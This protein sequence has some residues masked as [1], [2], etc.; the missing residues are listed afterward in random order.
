MGSFGATEGSRISVSVTA[1]SL[2][3]SSGFVNDRDPEKNLLLQE[4]V[5]A[6]LQTN[7]L[8]EVSLPIG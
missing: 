6:L 3:G 5:S 1:S 7:V 8:E 4:E 2:F